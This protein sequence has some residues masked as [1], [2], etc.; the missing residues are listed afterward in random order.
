[1]NVY[2]VTIL[3]YH[4]RLVEAENEDAAIQALNDET[5]FGD[6]DFDSARTWQV[7]DPR[8]IERAKRTGDF[9]YADTASTT[10]STST[11]NDAGETCG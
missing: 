2:E 5:R 11:S 10:Q 8:T 6:F 1:M 9:L 3:A 4:T 7:H